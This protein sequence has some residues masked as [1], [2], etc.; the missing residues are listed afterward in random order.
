MCI[1]L[2]TNI[3]HKAIYN[4]HHGV[5]TTGATAYHPILM[6]YHNYRDKLTWIVFKSVKNLNKTR[7]V[8]I[9]NHKWNPIYNQGK[10]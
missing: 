7:Q 5:C 2:L 3:V 10:I 8:R 9:S 4:Y 1:E 6:T